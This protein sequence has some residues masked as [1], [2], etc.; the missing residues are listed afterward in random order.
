MKQLFVFRLTLKLQIFFFIE[1][2]LLAISS[3]VI[4]VTERYCFLLFFCCLI[5]ERALRTMTVFVFTL[6]NLFCLD[7]TPWVVNNAQLLRGSEP[8]R[9]VETPRSLSEYILIE[10]VAAN[11]R[12]DKGSS[13]QSNSSDLYFYRKRPY[14][15]CVQLLVLFCFDFF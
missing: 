9:L 7:H 14:E 8:V 15:T 6:A 1:L 10:I 4:M 5:S 13:P 2:S 3:I 11:T 12:F